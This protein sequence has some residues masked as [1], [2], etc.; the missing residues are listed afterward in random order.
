M[1]K[2]LSSLLRSGNPDIRRQAITQLA[3][4][5]DPKDIKK[6]YSIASGERRTLFR[7]YGALDQLSAMEALLNEGVTGAADYVS[8]SLSFFIQRGSSGP[9][10][11]TGSGINAYSEGRDRYEYEVSN[12]HGMLETMLN[13]HRQ[14]SISKNDEYQTYLLFYSDDCEICAK[15]ASLLEICKKS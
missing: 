13:R 15:R 1:E 5:Q 4:S 10:V 9:L 14:E 11:D 7:R 3:K 2:Q 8:H 6:L 12:A